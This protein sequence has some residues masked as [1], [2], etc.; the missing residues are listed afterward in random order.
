MSTLARFRTR[1]NGQRI[2]VVEVDLGG[3]PRRAK[4]P[5]FSAVKLDW[6]AKFAKANGAPC[7][8]IM[9]IMQYLSWKA[10]SPTFTFS[11]TLLNKYGIHRDAKY[12]VLENLEAAG[13][14]KVERRGRGQAPI[15]TLTSVG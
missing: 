13:M 11:N 5:E 14:V 2:E 6:A 3:K 10:R 15:V 7:A 9:V 1:P 4:Q 8:L 12:R